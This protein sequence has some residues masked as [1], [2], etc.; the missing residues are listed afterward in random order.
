MSSSTKK[1]NSRPQ[2]DPPIFSR[3]YW[4]GSGTIELAC[5]RKTIGEGDEARD[6]INTT[7]KKTYRQD[8]EYKESS[9]FRPEELPL[10]AAALQ[11][12]FEFCCSEANRE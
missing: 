2:S 12:A 4:T 8:G 7:L 6:V 5:W 10:L 1:A 3:R 11:Q 9:S